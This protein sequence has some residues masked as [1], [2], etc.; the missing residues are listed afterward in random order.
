M[1]PKEQMGR[2]RKALIFLFIAIV[3][4]IA[5]P[6]ASLSYQ[7]ARAIYVQATKLHDIETRYGGYI[8]GQYVKINGNHPE[9]LTFGPLVQGGALERAGVLNGDVVVAPVADTT[10]L[11]I[12]LDVYQ[13]KVLHIDVVDGGDGLPLRQ[14]PIRQITLVAP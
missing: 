5:I 14:R 10:D 2:Y 9:V 7:V 12:Y 1:V 8:S 13:G 6:I 4:V 11:L 3:I